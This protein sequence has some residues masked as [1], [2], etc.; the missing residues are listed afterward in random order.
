MK[1]NTPSVLI[2]EDDADIR[3]LLRICLEA[4]D[5]RVNTATDGL[6]A[7]EQLQA[8]TRPALILL[9][10]STPR[11]DGEEFLQ[12]MRASPFASIPVVIMSGHHASARKA[13][14]LKAASCLMKPVEFEELLTT[15]RRLTAA[16]A[17]K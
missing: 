12:K 17:R 9:D 10:L 8:G 14:A 16:R 7:L 13:Q 2:I 3:E 6:D 5:Y 11:M 1:S 15:V 4:D